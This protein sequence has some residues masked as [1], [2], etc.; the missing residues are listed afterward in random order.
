MKKESAYRNMKK[1][2]KQYW[3]GLEQLTNHPEFVKYAE[4]EFPDELP[5][6]KGKLTGEGGSSRRDFLKLM[7][8]GIAAASL[9][10]CE[11]PVRKAIPYL[12]K[13]VD[14]NPGIPNYYASTYMNGGDYASIV[15]K[16]REGRPIKIEP[17]MLSDISGKGTTPQVEASVLSLYDSERLTSPMINGEPADWEEFDV[18]IK[19]ILDNIAIDGGAVRIISKTI[20][21]PSTKSVISEFINRYPATQHIMYDPVSV[22][23]M[24]KANEIS[25]AKPVIPEYHFDQANVVVS[26]AADFLGTWIN[27]GKF[28]SDFIKNRKIDASKKEMSRLYQY[29]TNFSLTGANA[30][31]RIPIRPSAEGLIVAN[32]FNKLA[33]KAGVGK[34][35]V[36]N[37]DVPHLDKA[38]EDLWSNKGKSL[39]VAGSNDVNI[40]LMVNT[41]NYILDNYGKK[42]LDINAPV[43]FRQ[44]ND[45]KM[46]A[47]VEDLKNKN[48][49]GVIFLDCN[50]VYDHP[51]GKNIKDGIKDIMLKISTAGRMDETAESVDYV[52]PD[53][54]FLESWNDA[55]PQKGFYSL[56][57]PAITPLFNTRQAQDSLLKWAGLGEK[58]YY[59]Y[60]RDYWKKHV[61]I[62]QSKEFDFDVF[63]DKCL[64]DG[65]YKEE[66]PVQDILFTPTA[67]S[68]NISDVAQ[69]LNDRYREN[70]V[71]IELALYETIAMRNGSEANNPWLQE[72]PDPVTKAC[73][74]NYLTISQAMARELN[75]KMVESDTILVELK[76]GGTV[77][78]LPALIQPGQAKGTVGLA[79]GYGRSK[80]GKVGNKVGV[81]AF[82]LIKTV[83]NI[84]SHIDF[85][86]V[87]LTV[88][89]EAAKIPQTQTHHTYMERDF[90]IREATLND[91]KNSSGDLFRQPHIAVSNA[92]E[93]TLGDK[94]VD[95]KM[96]PGEISLWKGHDYNNHHW[97]MTIDLNACI[98]C[99]ACSV[100]CQAENNVPVVGK[101]E[102]LNRR[103]MTWIR[104]DRYFSSEE[105]ASSYS[106]LEKAA[107]NPE[108]VFQPMMCQHCNNAPCETVCPV[109]ATTHSTEGLNQMVYNRCIGTRYCANNCPY[110]VRRFN[111]FKYQQNEQFP[112]NLAMN[113]DL[114]RMVLN[115]D[116]TVRSRGV[117]EKCS[118]C[119]QRIQYGKLEAKKDGRRVRDGEVVPA[120]ASACPTDAIT[121]GDI[122]DAESQVSK[123]LK[124]KVS[125]DKK[126]VGEERAYNVLEEVNTSPNVWYLAKIRNK[127]ENA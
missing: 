81:N 86:D 39:V 84:H 124:L 126:I 113:S 13:P 100:A 73:W 114:G 88:T 58:E 29:E 31:Y 111:W 32:L 72:L 51:L 22:Y 95:G 14:V 4:K 67:F 102:V 10:A 109:A 11:A 103:E 106:E 48:I 37:I 17:N 44:G 82:P 35:N 123:Q 75:I 125:E 19:S 89:T 116:V 40:Q 18:H 110:K 76:I 77:M 79:F 21:S 66:S 6:E 64:H 12:N 53:H 50:P 52:G 65:L 69:K 41:I 119:V 28:S 62:T 107:E 92:L 99:G 15:V 87:S 25:F 23:G 120:C 112:D 78:K 34:V 93:K 91:Y 54:H 33:G 8:F 61:F 97:N 80:A 38:A 36:P 16:T 46:Q 85:T 26:F 20:L 108:V 57:Q 7:G 43:Y 1:N 9:A 47:F 74:G 104:I 122:N 27:P 49:D 24:I 121:F 101:E 56:V 42:V 96:K 105:G 3:K 45:E 5:Y 59:N 115:P 83:D 30:D 68:V 63:F 118:F 60:L 71:S 94:K 127:E 90:V 55:A 117:M 70:N 98:G 2:K